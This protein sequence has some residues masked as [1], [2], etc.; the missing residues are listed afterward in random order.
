MT[1]IRRMGILSQTSWFYLL[2]NSA[3]FANDAG[4]DAFLIHRVKVS[5]VVRKNE[6]RLRIEAGFAK[7]NI[8]GTSDHWQQPAVPQPLAPA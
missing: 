3:F 4:E 5:S 2:E 1:A 7:F 6:P 8:T